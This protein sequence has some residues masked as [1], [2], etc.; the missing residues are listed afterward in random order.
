MRILITGGRGDIAQGIKKIL[1]QQNYEVS[2]PGK[3]EMNVTNPEQIATYF[4][5]IKPDILINCAGYI[6]PSSIKDSS[7]DEWTK[8]LEINLT[9]T[10][11]CSKI[12]ILSG[13]SVIINIVSTSAFE[14]RPNWGAYS[15]SKA[16][17]IS[18]TETLAREGYNCYSLSPSRTATKMRTNLFPNEDPKTLMKPERIGEFILKIM[19]KEFENGSHIILTKDN[20]II[21]PM[22]QCPK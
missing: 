15:A 11:L 22:R 16:G 21:I 3:E 14:G 2:A 8:H 18:L 12:A 20:S 19:N 9:G 13:C 7:Y 1:E 10:F 5:N 6:M 4:S 17:V